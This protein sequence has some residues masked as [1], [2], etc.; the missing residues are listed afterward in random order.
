MNF[1][2]RIRDF[3]LFPKKNYVNYCNERTE[4]GTILNLHIMY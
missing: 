2:V 1:G 4:F 3:I